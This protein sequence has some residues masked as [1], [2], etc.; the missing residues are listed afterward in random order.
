MRTR[1][2]PLLLLLLLAPAAG[3]DPVLFSAEIDAPQ[4]CVSGLAAGFE[5]SSFESTT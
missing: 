3:C 4:V 5:A 1:S 2:Y